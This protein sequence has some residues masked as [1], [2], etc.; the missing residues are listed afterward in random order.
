M[1]ECLCVSL[2]AFVYVCVFVRVHSFLLKYKE[3]LYLICI[4]NLLNNIDYFIM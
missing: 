4:D 1:L 3:N 2:C